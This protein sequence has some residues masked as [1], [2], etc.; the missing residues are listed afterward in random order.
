MT[1]VSLLLWAGAAGWAPGALRTPQRTQ[2]PRRAA[3]SVQMQADGQ[4]RPEAFLGSSFGSNSAVSYRQGTL[5]LED[6]SRL[7]G[8]SFGYEGDVAGELVFTTGMVGYP[9]SLTDPS[10]RGQILVMTYPIVGNYGV[11]EDGNDELGLPKF[12]EAAGVQ[13]AAFIVS[14]YSHHHSHWNSRRSLSEWLT[15]QRVPALYGLDTRLLT[16]K[17]REKGA[18]RARIEFEQAVTLPGAAPPALEDPNERNLAAEVSTTV[19]KVYGKGNTMKVLAVD[20]GIKAN[21]IRS[22]VQRD[23]QV[24][25]VPWDTPLLPLMGD[26]DALFLSN[27]P[28]NPATLQTTIGHIREVRYCCGHCCCCRAEVRGIALR[29]ARGELSLSRRTALTACRSS[30]HSAT[31]RRRSSPSSASASAIS[32]SA[33]PRGRARTSSHSATAGRTSPCSTC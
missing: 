24:T 8:V 13:V 12:F 26:N 2:A 28:G 30:T 7:R 14:D 9:E 33:S 1:F 32:S 16:K 19:T 18:L 3:A 4:S 29:P 11:P 21:I 6:G 25:L 15:Q 17:I 27:G 31:A 22:L 5:V 20:C 23:V 10:Y